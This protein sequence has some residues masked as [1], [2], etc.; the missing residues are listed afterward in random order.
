M[1]S[2]DM[3]ANLAKN[4]LEHIPELVGQKISYLEIGTFEGG[5]AMW[6]LD[7]VLTHPDS[8]CYCVDNWHDVISRK[9]SRGGRRKTVWPGFEIEY[10]ARKNLEKYGDR[11][12]IEKGDSADVLNAWPHGRHQ[13]AYVDGDHHYESCLKDS[14]AVWPLV[15]A[16]GVVIWDDFAVK[17]LASRSRIQVGKAVTDFLRTVYGQYEVLFSNNQMGVIK[18]A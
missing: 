7:N 18:R 5:S 1:L 13:L 17:P 4:V 12:V 16:G 11:V 15:D 6:M 14:L 8:R 3:T 10:A 9:K 2:I